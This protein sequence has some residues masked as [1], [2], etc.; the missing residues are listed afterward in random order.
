MDDCKACATPYHLGVKLTKVCESP[1]VNASLYHMLV[2]SLIYLT[3][4][5]LDISFAVSVVS[6]FMQDP[7]ERHWKVA[8]CIIYFLTGTSH[9][10]I[11]YSRST[12]LLVGYTE[13]D[14]DG[15]GDDKKSTFC[16]V[17]RFSDGPSVRSSK[18]HKV[19]SLLTT[20]VEYCGAII[21]SIEDVWI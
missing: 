6:R 18:K 1:K 3:H 19:V 4:S 15:D 2:G 7:R 5:P 9:F 17:S 12:D 8:K 14:W 11:K 13:S 21:A 10:G 20:K 16:F